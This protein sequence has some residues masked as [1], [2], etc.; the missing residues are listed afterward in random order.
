[1]AQSATVPGNIR[2]LPGYLSQPGQGFDS[3]VG[4]IV[5]KGGLKIV[6]DIGPMAG[7]YANC[8]SCGW[9]KDEVWRREQ[10]IGSHKVVIVFTKAKRLIVSFPDQNANFYALITSPAEMTDMLLMVLTYSP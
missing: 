9:T 3:Q 6:Y 10:I 2:L 7:D 5:R 4:A 1:M 8:K